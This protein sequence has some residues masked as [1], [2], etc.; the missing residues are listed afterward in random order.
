ML[1]VLTEY[2]L[3]LLIIIF[4]IL[5]IFF[6]LF[7]LQLTGLYYLFLYETELYITKL[8]KKAIGYH[9]FV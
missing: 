2:C 3:T 5:L 9:K 6:F 4:L 8:Q 7:S 1:T